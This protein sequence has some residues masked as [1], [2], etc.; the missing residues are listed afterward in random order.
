DAGLKGACKKSKIEI[1]AAICEKSYTKKARDDAALNDDQKETCYQDQAGYSANMI[2][3][4]D[5]SNAAQSGYG[6]AALNRTVKTTVDKLKSGLDDF[7]SLGTNEAPKK[8]VQ[9]DAV[10]DDFEFALAEEAPVVNNPASKMEA[11]R[12]APEPTVA[13]AVA[14]NDDKI[15]E[16]EKRLW[17]LTRN[18]ERIEKKEPEGIYQLR[19]VLRSLDVNEN[20]IRELIRGAMFELSSEET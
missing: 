3:R 7:L 12:R 19:T 5:Q 4:D 10:A 17:E 2:D 15:E 1:T 6:K 9:V 14:V 11:A 18:V 13:Q 8:A 16:L 20:A